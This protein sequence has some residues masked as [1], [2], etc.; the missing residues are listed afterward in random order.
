MIRGCVSQ[1]TGNLLGR[2]IYVNAMSTEVK[3]Q[4]E[5]VTQYT[6]IDGI[7]SLVLVDFKIHLIISTAYKLS[8]NG[9]TPT[10]SITEHT[11]I[12]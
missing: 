2:W 7:Q 9:C 4:V 11:S 5:W 12:L 6:L 1:Q 3:K 10:Y 8:H